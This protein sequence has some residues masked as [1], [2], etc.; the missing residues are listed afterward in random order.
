MTR[1]LCSAVMLVGALALAD[2]GKVAQLDGSATRKGKDGTS[3][4]LHKDVAIQLGDTIEVG[5][6]FLKI[7]LTDGSVLALS[8]KSKLVINEAEFEGQERKGFSAL[9]SAGSLWTK[10]KKAIGGAKYEVQTERAVAG[11]R[12]T[13]FRV[14]ADALVKANK[15]KG[16]ARKASIVRV[17]EGAVNVRPSAE[18]AKASKAQIKKPAAPKGPRVQVA[19]PQEVSEE[20][21]EEIFVDLQKNQQIIVGVDLW[22]QAEIDTASKNDAFSKWLDKNQ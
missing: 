5:K 10:V 7:E 18:V 9:L 8:D 11:V 12:G 20:K 4:E 3:E 1:L 2:V 6:G 14:D 16:Q 15:G 19:G 21:W 22:E 13:I 17:V